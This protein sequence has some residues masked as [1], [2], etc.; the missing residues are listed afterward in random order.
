MIDKFVYAV[1]FCSEVGFDGVEIH[2]AHGYL[3]SEFLSPTTNKR[4]DQY[5]GS[6]ENRVRILREIYAKARAVVRKDFIIGLKINSVEFQKGGLKTSDSA[7]MCKILEDDGFDFIELSGGTVEHSG[8]SN[9]RESTKVREAYFLDFAEQIIKTLKKT[10]IYCTGGF[11]TVNGMVKALQIGATQ[12]IGLGRPATQEPDLP[13][14]ILSGKT[15]GALKSLLDQNNY[16][17]T[18]F[19]SNT[20]MEQMGRQ[21]YNGDCCSG[22]MDLSDPETVRQFRKEIEKFTEVINEN[23]RLGK[24]TYGVIVWGP[25]PSL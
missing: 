6:V 19:A 14:K 5:G 16:E 22:I 12:G 18:N 9:P 1:R 10:V 17:E 13:K 4:T 7:E 8:F 24:P 21:P 3:L 25:K 15:S 23:G 11:R 2:A 20:Q